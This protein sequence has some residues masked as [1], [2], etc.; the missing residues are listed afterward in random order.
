MT[1]DPASVNDEVIPCNTGMCLT[2]D[3]V[4]I[5]RSHPVQLDADDTGSTSTDLVPRSQSHSRAGREAFKSGKNRANAASSSSASAHSAGPASRQRIRMA[6]AP[7]D[8]GQHLLDRRALRV[9]ARTGRARGN[10]AVNRLRSA[11]SHAALRSSR[12]A[13]RAE[14]AVKRFVRVPRPLAREHMVE[15]DVDQDP[16]ITAPWRFE[17]NALHRLSGGY[18][19]KRLFFDAARRRRARPPASPGRARRARNRRAG[20][21]AAR[22]RSGRQAGHVQ[23]GSC[24]FRR[25]A[26]AD[27]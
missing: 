16:G 3:P 14:N 17:A 18:P 12:S 20:C 23:D 9:R 24:G 13:Q 26:A 2:R 21:R 4:S 1:R 27:S 6:Q 10:S 19:Y 22:R 15:I 7:A 8:A 25:C 11:G 5:K